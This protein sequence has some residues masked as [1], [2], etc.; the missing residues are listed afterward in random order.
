MKKRLASA[1]AALALTLGTGAAVAEPASAA[2]CAW[3]PQYTVTAQSATLRAD[4]GGSYVIGTLYRGQ[5]FNGRG[6]DG[7]PSWTFGYGEGVGYG[8]ILKQTIQYSRDVYIC[9]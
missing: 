1:V 9:H 2:S 8:W 5:K 7:Q 4:P 3:Y 6:D